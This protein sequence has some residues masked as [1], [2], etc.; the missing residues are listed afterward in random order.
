LLRRR[1]RVPGPGR[2]WLYIGG[3]S[4]YHLHFPNNKKT[5]F[6]GHKQKQ[7]TIWI[8]SLPENK[9]ETPFFLHGG[10]VRRIDHH[11]ADSGPGDPHVRVQA[12][13]IPSCS[14]EP[15]LHGHPKYGD[16]ILVNNFAYLMDKPK[17]GDI[18][19]FSTNGIQ[20]WTRTRITSSGWS[21]C[22]AT[23]F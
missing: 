10:R 7:T 9:K 23:R 14:M 5:S 22:R 8:Q 17:R 12:F 3:Q 2:F 19:V 13:K 11:G 20:G 1:T 15:T 16:K 6:S 21:D 4:L 18:L